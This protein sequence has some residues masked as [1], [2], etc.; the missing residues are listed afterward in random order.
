MEG[1]E[2]VGEGN[3]LVENGIQLQA[4]IMTKIAFFFQDYGGVNYPR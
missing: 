1:I 4:S 3:S 2:E